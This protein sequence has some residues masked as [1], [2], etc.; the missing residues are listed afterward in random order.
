MD[1]DPPETP[2]LLSSGLPAS[3]LPA[4]KEARDATVAGRSGNGVSQAQR[5][6][7]RISSSRRPGTSGSSS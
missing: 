5:T 3:P 7:F 2:V 4:K 6:N 1:W